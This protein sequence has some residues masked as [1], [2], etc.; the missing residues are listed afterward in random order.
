MKR[1]NSLLIIFLLFLIPTGTVYAQHSLDADQAYKI[2]TRELRS[3]AN[4]AKS[5]AREVNPEKRLATEKQKI[6]V[7]GKAKKVFRTLP[8]EMN[9]PNDGS[10]IVEPKLHIIIKPDKTYFPVF[11]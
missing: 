7:P 2:S 1:N 5:Y 9:M 4:Q 11:E 3:K 10:V 8:R 6:T